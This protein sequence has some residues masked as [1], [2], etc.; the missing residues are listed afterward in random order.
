[1]NGWERQGREN[2]KKEAEANQG[3]KRG[4]GLEKYGKHWGWSNDAKKEKLVNNLNLSVKMF[5]NENWQ[6]KRQMERQLSST[7]NDSWSHLFSKIPQFAFANFLQIPTGR[8]NFITVNW[9]ISCKESCFLA[10]HLAAGDVT[11]SNK[12]L[13]SDDSSRLFFFS[14]LQELHERF[15]VDQLLFRL[16]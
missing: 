5:S 3:D 16:W 13:W 12:E 14:K 9:D 1:M 10:R 8:W 4:K 2:W 15:L 11:A 6:L 7:L